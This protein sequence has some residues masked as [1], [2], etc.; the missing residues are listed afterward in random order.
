VSAAAASNGSPSSASGGGL[1]GSRS[2]KSRVSTSIH[3]KAEFRIEHSV[4][5]S[6]GGRKARVLVCSTPEE[7]HR[8]SWNPK[9]GGGGALGRWTSRV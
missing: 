2:L 6:T 7:F 9:F 5:V 8:N 1:P 3:L 4:Y